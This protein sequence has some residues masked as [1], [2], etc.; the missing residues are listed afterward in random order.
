MATSTRVV[1]TN[2]APSN[3]PLGVARSTLANDKAAL[4][5]WVAF[6]KAC[7]SPENIT[8]EELEGDGAESIIMELCRWTSSRAIPY[9]FDE[10]LERPGNSKCNRLL[11]TNTLVK[12]I[13][14]IIKFL[15]KAYPDHPDWKDLPDRQDAVPKWWSD[16]IPLFKKNAR[17]FE[18][19]Y[20]GDGVFGVNDIK[21]LYQDLG[22]DDNNGTEPLRICDQKNVS[23]RLVMNASEANNNLQMLAIIHSVADAIGRGGEA[24]SQTFRDWSFD[25]SWNVTNTPWKEKKTIQGYAVPRVADERWFAN[26]YCMMGMYGMCE[27]GLY[28]SPH[29]IASGLMLAVFPL[30]HGKTDEYCSEKI[31]RVIRSALPEKTRDQFSAKSLRQAGISQCSKHPHMTIFHLCALSGHSTQTTLD[32]YLDTDDVGRGVPAVNALHGKNNLFTPVVVPTLDALGEDKESALKL[33]CALFQCNIPK[34]SRGNELYPLLEIFTASLIMHHLQIMKDCGRDNRVTCMLLDKAQGVHIVCSDSPSLPIDQTLK[35]WSQIIS[36]EFQNQSR[37]ARLSVMDQPGREVYSCIASLMENV[38]SLT[39]SNQALMKS[40]RE[41]ESKVDGI[42][43]KFDSLVQQHA[44][45]QSTIS[46]LHSGNKV[47]REE[48][49]IMT[50]NAALRSQNLMSTPQGHNSTRQQKKR[51]R[52]ESVCSRIDFAEETKA[53]READED[54]DEQREEEDK[55][56]EVDVDDDASLDDAVGATAPTHEVTAPLVHVAHPVNR[57]M[58]QLRA[59]NQVTTGAAP[60]MKKR[61]LSDTLVFLAQRGLLRHPTKLE[62]VQLPAKVFTEKHFVVNCLE[63]VDYVGAQNHAVQSGIQLLRNAT[64]SAEADEQIELNN[65]ANQ[66]VTACNQ[67]LNEFVPPKTRRQLDQTI[68]GMGA[69]IKCYKQRIKN[70]KN[71]T[72]PVSKVSLISLEDLTELES[73]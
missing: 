34:F 48:L 45:D 60:S 41:L 15:R 46:S 56:G 35:R 22:L 69:R 63:L 64:L 33:M 40:N 51:Q 49:K 3:C 7:E 27:N 36:R 31:T 4:N 10:N 50:K 5:L 16:L 71:M 65:A 25:Y 66:I 67:Q 53:S 11:Q 29:E 38:K 12:Y 8:Q 9:N 57:G 32:S 37:Q 43:E 62:Q 6:R 30:L 61:M 18:L 59:C 28:R 47:L 39:E 70:A 2:I 14:K 23:I 21:P 72:S 20:Q 73:G 17:S 44:E 13:G 19:Q 42:M 58:I 55:G 1:A 68:A 26:W 24:K 54:E 52:G